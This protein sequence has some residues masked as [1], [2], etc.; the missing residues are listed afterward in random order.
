MTKR[1]EK[2]DLNNQIVTMR[3]DVKRS[4]LWLINNLNNRIKFLK[5]KKG[6]EIEVDKNLE[7]VKKIQNEMKLL[8][9]LAIDEISKFALC[10]QQEKLDDKYLSTLEPQQQAL[11]RIASHKFVQLHV[12][13]F[14]E[15]YSCPND[16]LIL[17]VRSLGLQYQKKKNKP[18]THSNETKGE[19]ST[20]SKSA[21]S[22][23]EEVTNT[24]PLPQS[25]DPVLK[26]TKQETVK[27]HESVSKP[28]AKKK[29]V[30]S[31]TVTAKKSSDNKSNKV[32]NPESPDR[33]SRTKIVWPERKA[34]V[35]DKRV[36]TMEIKHFTNLEISEST[37]PVANELSLTNVTFDTPLDSF[38]LGGVD[39]PE[40]VTETKEKVRN[41]E[42]GEFNRSTTKE[43]IGR[44]SSN[45]RKQGNP[46]SKNVDK[47]A[48]REPMVVV[49]PF[50]GRKAEKQTTT[51]SVVDNEGLHPSWQAKKREKELH[52]NINQPQGKK[53]KFDD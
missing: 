46:P 2:I 26:P 43:K 14:R 44:N 42:K 32:E 18:D 21:D 16:K 23:E 9:G 22:E 33:K 41:V 47:F 19:K 24:L 39:P 17:L 52:I 48:N 8:K 1:I 11:L 38:F 12:T 36:G 53:I 20:T 7:K 15:T 3:K 13:K 51:D 6:K 50:G 49:R 30:E 45:N 4:R 35:I 34:P 5:K 29:K 27:L 28:S 40:E 31:Q 10:N 37:T 25:I